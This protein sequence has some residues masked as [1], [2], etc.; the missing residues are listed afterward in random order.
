[1][2]ILDRIPHFDERSRQFPVRSLF[3]GKFLAPRKRVW[4]PTLEPLDQ[5]SEG[6]CVGFAWAGEL[7]A[8]PI[9]HTVDDD[10]ARVL[11]A[12]ARTQDRAMGNYW[13]EGA[14]VLAGAKAAQARGLIS[15]YHWAFGILDVR[16][17]IIRKGPVVLGVNWYESMYYPE[18]MPSTGMPLVRVEGSVIGGHAILCNGYIP[19]HREYG[20]VYV[21]RNSWG[22]GWGVNGS[23]VIRSADLIRLLAENGEACIP[24]DK[25]KV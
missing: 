14:S 18:P 15:R 5:G 8:T 12:Q 3:E 4:R 23:A 2:P 17:T 25:A 6:A 1:M 21:L 22:P 19:N 13:P 10:Y 9:Q 20:D 7:G 24:T 16:D 11:Y